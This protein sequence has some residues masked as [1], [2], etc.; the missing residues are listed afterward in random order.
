[1]KLVNHSSLSPLNQ[2]RLLLF[3]QHRRGLYSLWLFL[4]LFALSLCS[5]LIA[6]NKPL[7]VSYNDELF[8]P[9]LTSYPE[10][11]FGGE[12]ETEADYKDS[13]VIDLIE[14]KGL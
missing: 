1:M 4:F 11:V 14:S 5:E 8:F 13:Y 3:K 12:F 6:N 7:L 2:R 9:V 10:T